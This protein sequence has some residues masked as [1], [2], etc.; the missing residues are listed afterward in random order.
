MPA[1]RVRLL[2]SFLHI[3]LFLLGS[4]PAHAQTA[5]EARDMARAA[6][7]LEFRRDA[8]TATTGDLEARFAE[9]CERGY[10]PAC[11]RS[12]WLIDGKPDPT[13]VMQVLEPSCEAGDPV[14]CLAVGWCYDLLADKQRSRD[15]SERLRKRAAKDFKELCDAGEQDACHEYA[16]SLYY[17]GL[18]SD[19]R[20]GLARWK[21]ACDAGAMQSCTTLARLN[22][23][24]GPGVTVNRKTAH[25]YAERAC[26]AGYAEGCRVLGEMDDAT[27]PVEQLDTFYGDL[28]NAGHRDSCWRLARIYFD[29]IHPEPRDGRLLELFSR[30]CDLGHARSCFEAGRMMQDDAKAAALFGRACELGDPAGC[31]SQVDFIL[32]GRTPGSVKTASK[33][34]EVACEVRESAAACTAL[35]YALLDG[36]DLPRDA[37]RGRKLLQRTCRD[38][39]PDPVACYTLGRAFEEGLG[40][41]RDRTEASK[42]Y[43]WACTAGHVESCVR[44]GDLLVSD[45][46]V[47]RDDHEALNMYKRA[48]D[49]GWADAC[50]KAGIILDEATY[51]IEDRATALTLYD[52]GCQGGNAMGCAR[53]GMLR[54]KGLPNAGPDMKGAR[55]AY[56]RAIE[57]GS[58]DAKRLNARL[59]WNGYGGP[60]QRGRA[61]QLCREACQSGDPVACR[62][63][64]FL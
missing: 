19:P 38:D 18:S 12:S 14:A 32:A 41:D 45:V 62:G 16:W 7:R 55:V 8:L 1:L 59:L 44:R 25:D 43:R 31:S 36:I 9:A 46:G 47:R 11:R 17:H 51:V 15:E 5:G 13:K 20:P 29:G 64:A 34:F 53:L 52:K 10:A 37:E 50:T 63:P 57:L 42:Y 54:E 22:R 56:E 4:A 23:D 61:K 24:G 30:A 2:G 28:C 3:L 58:L 48:C 60:R 40:G 6:L 39:V 21:T 27:W 49:G 35:A 26:K 33:A